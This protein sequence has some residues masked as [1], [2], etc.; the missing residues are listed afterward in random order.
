M[1][2]YKKIRVNG[3]TIDEHRYIMEQHLGRPLTFN[4]VVH[5]IDGNKRNNDLSNLEVVS[6][7]NHSS[8][9]KLG[10]PLSEE[11]REKL[12]NLSKE[13]YSNVEG[14]S[15][16]SPKIVE[17]VR[18]LSKMYKQKEIAELLG[19]SKYAVYRIL[20]GVSFSYIQ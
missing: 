8:S 1:Y 3:V 7:S 10:N 11:T 14:H 19:L 5:H 16:I 15:N 12:S 6:R 20:K 2:A 17:A 9:H 18:N 13:K 4:E